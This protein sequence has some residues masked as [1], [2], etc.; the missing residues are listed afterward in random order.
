MR[1]VRGAPWT[2]AV[3]RAPCS[4]SDALTAALS[5]CFTPARRQGHTHAE[6]AVELAP[7]LTEAT[8]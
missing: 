7:A 8:Q 3:E 6:Q 1:S 5:C 4:C 2:T